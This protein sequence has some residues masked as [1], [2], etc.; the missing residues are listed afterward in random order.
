MLKKAGVEIAFRGQ[1]KLNPVAPGQLSDWFPIENCNAWAKRAIVKAVNN[2]KK[3][4]HGVRQRRD[5]GE[6][7]TATGVQVFGHAKF[8]TFFTGVLKSTC[9]SDRHS[10]TALDLLLP[11]P[12]ALNPFAALTRLSQ[13]SPRPT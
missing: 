7:Q 6:T 1:N 13:A 3:W 5:G 9:D 12:W 11:L 10:E 4:R 8:R 2:S